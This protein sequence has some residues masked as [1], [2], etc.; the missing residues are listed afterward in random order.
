MRSRVQLGTFVRK[1]DLGE[2]INL[3]G[4]NV[5]ETESRIDGVALAHFTWAA[6]DPRFLLQQLPIIYMKSAERIRHRILSD[7]I[8]RR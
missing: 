8:I 3:H 1:G 2:I 6:G 5:E 4:E 7:D